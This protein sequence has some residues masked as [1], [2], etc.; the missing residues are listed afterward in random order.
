VL[1]GAALSACSGGGDDATAPASGAG[2][3]AGQGG[4]AAVGGSAG[5]A[6]DGS[7]G[8]GAGVKIDGSAGGGAGAS[9]NGGSSG[10]GGPVG[11]GGSSGDGATPSS[12]FPDTSARIAIL[13]D[14]F[15]PLS[16]EQTA[17]AA[18]HFVG[19]EK[20]VVG[21]THAL[22]ALNPDFVVL[23][24]HLAM[25]Q[26]AP[27]TQFILDGKT[28]SNDYPEVSTHETYFWHDTQTQRVESTS[29]HK[30]LMNVADPGFRT[31]WAD[32]IAAQIAAGEYDGVFLD[33]ASPALLQGEASSGDARLA[34]TAV[35]TTTFTELG[36]K[37]WIAAWEDWI[38]TLEAALSAKGYPLIPNTGAFIT[39][40]DNTNYGLSAGIFSEGFA[41]P[42][43]VL[44]DWK[45]S[46]NELLSLSRAGKIMI[47]QNY[48]ASTD[49]VARRMYY[50]GNYLLVRGSKT[51]LDYFAGSPLEWY[52]E[53]DID[54]GAGQSGPAANVDAL[55]SGGVYR[56]DFANGV[57]LVNPG[58]ADVVVTLGATMKRVVPS[59][60]GAI[61]ADGTASGTLARTDVTQVTVAAH[62]AEILER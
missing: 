37:T 54:L 18:S 40:W 26:S 34:A 27:A 29:D 55:L 1:F 47:L 58:T 48:L 10:G 32:S 44:A 61:A 43:F 62:G 56:R 36:G 21:V 28:W 24:Y 45:Q 19:T 52:P 31:Y 5:G 46:L 15:P 59:G 17:F 6:L 16:T 30:L 13:A 12:R 3:G 51:Y 41:D 38:T 23:H 57:V 11:S 25:W 60:G 33:S 42:S 2:G 22:R 7:A 35:K 50:L 20:Q 49:D 14:Q 8:G 9:G 39:T 4:G 53:W